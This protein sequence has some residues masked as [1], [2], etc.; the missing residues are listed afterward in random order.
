MADNRLSLLTG[1]RQE[2][3]LYL[4]FDASVHFIRLHFDALELFYHVRIIPHPIPKIKR[5]R[6]RTRRLG[7]GDKVTCVP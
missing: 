5:G 3:F 4:R 1:K 6:S 7:Q 2:C